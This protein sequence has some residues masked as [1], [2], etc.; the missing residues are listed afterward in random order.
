MLGFG[1]VLRSFRDFGLFQE[2]LLLG[3]ILPFVLLPLNLCSVLFVVSDLDRHYNKTGSS[4]L[5]LTWPWMC[6]STWWCL[7]RR[8]GPSAGVTYLPHHHRRKNVPALL[9]LL[10]PVQSCLW[11][12]LFIYFFIFFQVHPW[13]CEALRGQGRTEEARKIICK[14]ATI[15]KK[16]IPEDF[17]QKVS[18]Y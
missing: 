4:E 16:Q 8:M 12:S 17:L 2:L 7:G 18:S 3:L 9:I 1:T 13:I 14:V 15:N 10:F 11:L 5:I 6:S